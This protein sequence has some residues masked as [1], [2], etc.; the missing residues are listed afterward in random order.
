[1]ITKEIIKITN[2]KDGDVFFENG[3]SRFAVSTYRKNLINI[4]STETGEY[5]EDGL[6]LVI[7]NNNRWTEYYYNPITKVVMERDLGI[8]YDGPCNNYEFNICRD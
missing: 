5:R 8:H 3:K 6:Y 7:E 1:M 2:M 4:K